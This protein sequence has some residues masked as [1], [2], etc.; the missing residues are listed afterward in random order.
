MTNRTL[1]NVLLLTLLSTSAS[2]KLVDNYQGVCAFDIDYTLAC[3]G[4]S[5]AV[6]A[7]KDADFAL[8]ID[9]ARSK[10]S[11]YQALDSL[12]E[13]RGFDAEFIATA[14]SQIGLTGPFQY[15]EEWSP[16][17]P[18][19]QQWAQKSYGLRN[20]AQYYHARLDDNE[21]K[22]IIL[23]DDLPTNVDQVRPSFI[24]SKGECQRDE[25]NNCYFDPANSPSNVHFPRN[26]KIYKGTWIGFLCSRWYDP[27]TAKQDVLAML[28]AK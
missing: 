17:Q 9:T 20:I 13:Q 2:A 16:E 26:W 21:S 11:A 12:L 14:K 24:D 1:G 28:A 7:C 10:Q 18:A 6:Q 4:A 22:L 27:E 23:F 3:E 19:E 8:A 5:A 15:K 25:A